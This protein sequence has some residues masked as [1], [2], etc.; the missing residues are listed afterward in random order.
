MS[1]PQHRTL[2]NLAVAGSALLALA[3]GAAFWYA[4]ERG[5][6]APAPAGTRVTVNATSC[7]PN[8]ITVPGGTRSFEIVNASDRPIEWEILDGVLVVAERENIAPG[9]HQIMTVSLS[10]GDY[11]ITCGLLSNPRGTLHVTPSH[12]ASAAAA[13]VTLKKFLGPLSEY[14]VYLVLESRK[15]VR[16][17]EALRDAI[18]AGDLEAARSAWE[19]ARIPYR[20]LEPL[21]MRLSD[22]ENRI[23]PNAAYL[24]GREADP[25]FTGYHR[26]EY[27]LFAQ[28]SLAGLGPLSD[29]LVQDLGTLSERL[30]AMTL[31]PALLV[32]LPGA[33][34][35]Q[36][37]QAQIPGGEDAY[38]RNDLPE[39]AASLAGIGKITGLLRG[40]LEDVDPALDAEI[41]TA[42]TRADTALAALKTDGSFPAYDRV[43]AA[44]RQDLAQAL[45]GL[46]ASLDKMQPV[47]GM[48]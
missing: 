30:K 40:V 14:R 21:A 20:H 47:I 27:G 8:E 39:F 36:L 29:Q 13:E 35:G 6:Q 31:D 46:Q 5:A 28:D 34:A 48:N 33:M 19:A 38:A 7:T 17:A 22:L 3:G 1:G 12:E 2:L 10:P 18:A 23:D 44:Q 26:I 9:F 32:S 4:A 42:L 16:A 37:A 45:S 11:D 24:A 15:A 43:S 25:A 41:G